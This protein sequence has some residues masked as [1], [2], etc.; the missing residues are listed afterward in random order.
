MLLRDRIG[1]P[2][3]PSKLPDL[4]GVTQGIGHSLS[5]DWYELLPSGCAVEAP[6]GIVT[7]LSKTP[8]MDNREGPTAFLGM[9]HPL[10]RG[11]QSVGRP[12]QVD[13]ITATE[14]LI[15]EHHSSQIR[16]ELNTL[17]QDDVLAVG[18]KDT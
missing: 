3:R 1:G 4:E 18:K 10:K 5:M 12:R 17:C 9:G 6:T 11:S 7:S 8:R 13:C 14:H 2:V 15:E 16:K